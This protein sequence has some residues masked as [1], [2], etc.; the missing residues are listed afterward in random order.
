MTLKVF[1]LVLAAGW[2]LL[3]IPTLLWWH[4]SV[5]WVAFCSLY[6]NAVTHVTASASAGAEKAVKDSS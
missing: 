5:L 2:A 4:D 1:H 6:A 3:A